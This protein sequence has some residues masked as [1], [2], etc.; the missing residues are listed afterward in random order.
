MEDSMLKLIF[1]VA[2]QQMIRKTLSASKSWYSKRMNLL[3][4]IH[5]PP[6]DL[7]KKK[8]LAEDCLFS[9]SVNIVASRC[10]YNKKNISLHVPVVMDEL[11]R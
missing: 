10:L 4:V 8:S 11:L 9:D 2:V 3:P 1:T 5:Q 7:E 6:K